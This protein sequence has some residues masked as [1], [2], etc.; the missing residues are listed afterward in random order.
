MICTNQNKHLEPVLQAIKAGKAVFVEKPTVSTLEDFATLY[1]VMNSEERPAVFTVGLNRRYSSYVQKLRELIEGPIDHITF[2]VAVPYVPPEHWTLD[3]IEGGGR[4]IT[5]GEHFFDLCNLLI[6]K[7]AISVY[8]HGLGNLPDDLRKLT[9]W[10]ATIHYE[11]AVANIV[12]NESGAPGFPREQL[13]VMGRG[14]VAVL[15]DF[16]QLTLYGKKKQVI[17]NGKQ[18]DMGQ[19]REL[20]EF[21][22]AIRGEPNQMLTWEESSAASLCMFAAQESIRFG[23]P[24]DLRDFQAGLKIEKKE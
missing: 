17:G 15:D 1:Q 23:Q 21:V 19:K 16:A 10:A 3:E 6:G 22:A 11:E 5:E 18:A 24:I 4:L 13:V 8:A 12:F 14:Q 7:P 9:A 2:N 20:K